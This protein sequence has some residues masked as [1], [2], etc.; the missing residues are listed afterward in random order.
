MIL[1]C[2]V[3]AGSAGSIM[4]FGRRKALF[5]GTVIGVIGIGTTLV[6]T[7]TPIIIGR[8]WFGVS[9]GLL[10]VVVPK[11]TQEQ[12][13]NHYYEVI[14]PIFILGQSIGVL[15]A[16]AGGLFLPSDPAELLKSNDWLWIY[17]WIPLSIYFVY[18]L[19]LIFVIKY[20]T[21]QFLL[22]EDKY[23]KNNTIPAIK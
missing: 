12:V 4:K 10:S 20:D 22:I 2:V 13:P 11:T 19:G 14:S 15:V 17:G 18:F 7:L 8:F 1:G 6:G 21:I 5:L 9:S 3:G 16:F 23:K